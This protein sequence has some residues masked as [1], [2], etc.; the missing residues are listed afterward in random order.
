M[1]V[2]AW[3]SRSSVSP[4]SVLL[5]VGVQRGEDDAYET[6]T[7]DREWDE[8]DEDEQNEAPL[9][10]RGGDESEPVKDVLRST[11]DQLLRTSRGKLAELLSHPCLASGDRMDDTRGFEARHKAL[12]E[13]LLR[14]AAS[15]R[16]ARAPCGTGQDAVGN[17]G[18]HCRAHA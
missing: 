13:D 7:F 3:A 16:P 10:R 6:G 4:P 9:R 15:R 17:R 5:V 11:P 14:R 12:D 18:Q 8:L 1:N 2:A